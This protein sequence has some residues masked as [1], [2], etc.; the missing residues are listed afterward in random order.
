MT[1]HCEDADIV[2]SDPDNLADIEFFRNMPA[3]LTPN[4]IVLRG[5]HRAVRLD[6][7][8]M[9]PD[10]QCKVDPACPIL[11]TLLEESESLYFPPTTKPEKQ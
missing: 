9:F 6:N 2:L 8:G 5:T 10:L 4:A 3:P 11:T 7:T 1:G